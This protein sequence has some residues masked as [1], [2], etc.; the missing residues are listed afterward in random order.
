MLTDYWVL[1]QMI[2]GFCAF[3][4]L[5]RA[6]FSAIS[7]IRFWNNQAL[8]EKQIQLE[9]QGYLLSS[10]LNIVLGFQILSLI[11]FLNTVNNHL[12]NLIKGAM[13]ATG[14]L[15]VNDFGYPLLFLKLLGVLL[16][17]VFLVLNFWDNAE[18]NYPLTPFKY[19]LIFPILLLNL[20]DIMLSLSFF[21]SI[22]PDIIATCCSV[23]FS[24]TKGYSGLLGT[25]QGVFKDFTIVIW[26]FSFLILI[27]I[28]FLLKGQKLVIH[29]LHLVAAI[30]FVF[31]SVFNLKYQFVKYIYGLPT[32][33][34]LF[35][36]FWL[37]YQAIG[38]ILFGSYYLVVGSS[39]FL[40][41]YVI[42]KKHLNYS[43]QSWLKKVQYLGFLGTIFSFILPYLYWWL[44][45]GNL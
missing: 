3:F 2:A 34:C 21:S 22:E 20:S 43:H 30:V 38:Y 15:E 37:K 42:V 7:F 18:P 12:P 10:I 5:L 24:N 1:G 31:F 33:N 19:W 6:S 8:S 4:L 28:H 14:V 29:V 40:L 13:C 39:T 41:L 11:L 45:S 44:W 23:Q 25:Y 32:H 16:Y 35:D 26:W 9:R 27:L 17:A 36:I